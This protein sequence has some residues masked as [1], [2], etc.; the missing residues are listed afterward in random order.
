MERVDHPNGSFIGY[1]YDTRGNR[2]SITT[3]SGT[4]TYTYD[5]LNRLETV[6]DIDASVTTYSYDV[7]AR[8]TTIDLI[9]DLARLSDDR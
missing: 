9:H 8:S 5:T 1:G 3:A 2:T 7:I 6:S 4:V